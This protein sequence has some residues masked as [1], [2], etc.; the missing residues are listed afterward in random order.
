MNKKSKMVII[1]LVA[2]LMIIGVTP[3][4]VNAAYNGNLSF[5]GTNSVTSAIRIDSPLNYSYYLESMPLETIYINV[6]VV[7]QFGTPVSDATVHTYLGQSQDYQ[8][9][10][11]T[12]ANGIAN[13][14]TPSVNQDS[15]YRIKAEK[16]VDGKDLTSTI[17]VTIRNRY[18]KVYASVNPVDEGTEF[19]AIVRD[20][21][22]Q[23]VA[24]ASVKFNGAIKFT[25][26]N[27]MTQ[28]FT[29]PWINVPSVSSQIRAH[30][31]FTIEASAP[32]RGYDS[33]KS[34]VTVLDTGSA[35]S[36]LVYG[37]IRDYDFAPLENVKITT[38]KGTT[39]YTDSNG[40]Y[41]FEITPNEGGESITFTAS[42]SGYET[43]SV[44]RWV[45]SDDTEP[46]HVNFWMPD[47]GSGGQ[48]VP[49]QQ[50]YQGG[51]GSQQ[52]EL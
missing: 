13:W 12:N 20:Q 50:Q 23:P 49:G 19:N 26:S 11:F 36:H 46:V 29:A 39:V 42:L 1:G 37:Q 27:G 28:A 30:E 3:M 5:I 44:T 16:F 33:G 17:Y 2:F 15:V 8:W 9:R 34:N 14:P 21:D 45:N 38:N 4:F 40:N 52:S 43:Q 22:N 47:D 51:Q 6:H 48:G 18:L 25:D 7:N 24:L 32:L 41:S 10:G 35:K 31:N